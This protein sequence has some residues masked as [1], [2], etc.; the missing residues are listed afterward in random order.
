MFTSHPSFLKMKLTLPTVVFF[1]VGGLPTLASAVN[2]NVAMNG[3]DRTN[4][5]AV[6]NPCRTI[7]Y[8]IGRALPNQSQI[9]VGP[10]IYGDYNSD[11]DFND[12]QDEPNGEILVDKAI[13]LVSVAGSA[14]TVLNVPVSISANGASLGEGG[15][16]D[17]RGFMLKDTFINVYATQ[18]KVLNNLITGAGGILINDH[19]LP[20]S[21][22]GV[23]SDVTLL[24]FNTIVGHER[25]GNGILFNKMYPG[26]LRIENNT[27]MG[28]SYGITNGYNPGQN[29]VDVAVE[30]R[31]NTLSNNS[32]GLGA[33]TFGP[34]HNY[35]IE[36]NT[37]SAN[38][39]GLLVDDES[40][41]SEEYKILRNTF[42]GSEFS[43]INFTESYSAS[44]KISK[45]NIYG[46]ARSS[47][48]NE[49][50][51][52]NFWGT[53]ANARN[54]FWGAASGPGSDPADTAVCPGMNMGNF[55]Y[56]PFAQQA[57]PIYP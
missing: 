3:I 6:D 36:K 18:V 29:T 52:V 49:C 38:M 35:T 46:N 12:L 32:V 11:G 7:S 23:V 51:L 45:N 47:N 13:P 48:T 17:D 26:Q 54:N 55:T 15:N 33:F 53:T 20:V 42:V 43:A 16:S 1:A 37:F 14:A 44:M 31:N 27:I 22:P 5:G 39:E 9:V 25:Q 24:R 34:A 28:K 40:G 19:H 57:F 50:A 41:I 8:G 21:D 2:I 10:G 30:I 4:C 56:L